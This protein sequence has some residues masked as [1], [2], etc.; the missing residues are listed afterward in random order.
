[1]TEAV[2]NAIAEHHPAGLVIDLRGFEYRFGDWIGAVPLR[3]LGALGSGRVCI[4]ATGAT[5]AALRSLWKLGKLDTLFPLFEESREAERYLSGGGSPG[6]PRVLSDAGGHDSMLP[7]SDALW[8]QFGAAIDMLENA[9]VACP[10]EVWGDRTQRPE[11]WYLAYHTL[12]WLDFYLSDS[13]EG[14][15]PP[16]PFT[17]DEMDPAGLL[18]GRVYTKEE[19]RN[20]LEYG[21]RKCRAALESLTDEKAG[22]RFRLNWMDFSLAELHLYNLRHVQHGAAQLNLILR[23]RTDS[24]P[25][26]VA[27]TKEGR[28]GA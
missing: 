18:P 24:A 20:Y 11:F 26:W 4:L 6:G 10:D 25:G 5:A 22:Q 8:R 17:L 16:A 21:R 13:P 14:F 19:L 7:P 23:Q 9:I 12:F 3:A 2:A 27:R 15:A 28:A 1:M